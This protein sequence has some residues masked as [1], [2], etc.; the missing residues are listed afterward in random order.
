MIAL[1]N[2]AERF[3]GDSGVE[4]DEDLRLSGVPSYPSDVTFTMAPFLLKN[5]YYC[6]HNPNQFR[7]KKLWYVMPP[8]N[9]K[10]SA[11]ASTQELSLKIDLHAEIIF[12]SA[13]S[14][15]LPVKH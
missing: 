14:S 9:F 2:A 1:V 8:P 3:R 13:L 5:T 4:G 12:R 10:S 15:D 6:Y 11:K 7:E